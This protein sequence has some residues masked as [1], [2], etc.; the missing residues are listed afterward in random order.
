MGSCTKEPPQMTPGH[1]HSSG[2]GPFVQ[3]RERIQNSSFAPNAQKNIAMLSVQMQMNIKKTTS[4]GF[5]S[6][7]NELK[8]AFA[9]GLFG[10]KRGTAHRLQ[11][12]VFVDLKISV[13]RGYTWCNTLTSVFFFLPTRDILC[14][15]LAFVDA[16]FRLS[17]CRNSLL[18]KLQEIQ[19]FAQL[20][21]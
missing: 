20:R 5:I 9:P 3:V 18:L 16:V 19:P 11:M 10:E 12:D 6:E 4:Q 13:S 2:N 17:S 14:E 7:K 8:G 15:H 21:K 1:L